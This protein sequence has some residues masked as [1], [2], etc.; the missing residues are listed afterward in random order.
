MSGGQPGR[1]PEILSCRHINTARGEQRNIFVEQGL[2]VYVT[3]Y[4]KGYVRK[5]DVKVIH[6]YFPREIGELLLCYI[7][8]V[9]PFQQPLEVTIWEK[10]QVSAFMWP[11]DPDGKRWTSQRLPT[12]LQRESRIGMGVSL[13]IQA[14]REIVIG[15]SRNYMR[16]GLSFHADTENEETADDGLNDIAEVQAGHGWHVVGLIY[17]RGIMEANGEVAS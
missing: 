11:S 13:G 12:V 6:R 8:S 2:M 17:A 10:D 7:W 5:G 14:Y 15:I 16:E 4:H 1:G 9:L 3:R